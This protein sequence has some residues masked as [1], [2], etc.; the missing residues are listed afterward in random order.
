[1]A[2]PAQVVVL[3]VII[4]RSR[5]RTQVF[6]EDQVIYLHVGEFS[7]VIYTCTLPPPE[8]I[9]DPTFL[10]TN[11]TLFAKQ[12]GSKY[13]KEM[14]EIINSWDTLCFPYDYKY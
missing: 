4:L 11:I 7:S 3:S 10:E 5:V 6:V 13:G 1:M 2:A 8:H 9:M 14:A 12:G